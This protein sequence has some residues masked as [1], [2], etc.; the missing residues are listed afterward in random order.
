M[1]Y[2]FFDIRKRG[3][4]EGPIL[5]NCAFPVVIEAMLSLAPKV[6]IAEHLAVNRM[7]LLFISVDSSALRSSQNVGRVA[8]ER[9]DSLSPFLATLIAPKSRY[10][11]FDFYKQSFSEH[12]V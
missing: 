5:G 1:T 8:V 6:L 4:A 9:R 3:E 12:Y 2:F 10:S 11:S 7:H